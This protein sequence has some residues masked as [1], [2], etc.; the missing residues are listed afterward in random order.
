MET[1]KLLYTMGTTLTR[2]GQAQRGPQSDEAERRG[3]VA[4]RS[5]EALSR[6][7]LAVENGDWVH[8]GRS[9]GR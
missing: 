2:S 5:F 4:K 1:T 6:A 7:S 9:P 8:S 3:G